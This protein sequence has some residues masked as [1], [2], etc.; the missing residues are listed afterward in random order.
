MP[1]KQN[2]FQSQLDAYEADYLE[3]RAVNHPWRVMGYFRDGRE[4]CRDLDCPR[5]GAQ[6]VDRWTKAGERLPSR[7]FY[8]EGYLFKGL[9]YRMAGEEIRV[10]TISRVKIY[11]SEDELVRSYQ[12][13][14][15]KAQPNGKSVKAT[16]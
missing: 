16:A 5:C 4:I 9:G 3:C 12:G 11:A 15:A 2:D 14:P 13:Q 7:I 10:A 1:K 6:R 8:P